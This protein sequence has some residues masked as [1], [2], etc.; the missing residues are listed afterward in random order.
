LAL[1]LGFYLTP[2]HQWTIRVEFALLLRTLQ[3]K[4]KDEPQQAVESEV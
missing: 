4:S 2:H 3:Q 1:L